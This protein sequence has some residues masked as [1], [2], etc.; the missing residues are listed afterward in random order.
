MSYAGHVMDMI[1]RIKYNESLKQ[2]RRDRY[3]M[4]K[5]A[6]LE[7]IHYHIKTKSDTI[8]KEKLEGIKQKIR[9]DLKREYKIFLIKTTL[10]T[11]FITV[12][13]ALLIYYRFFRG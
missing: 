3:K 2:A 5:E 12:A 1:N 10:T 8:P 4:L 9:A 7:G 13:I 11:T 6:Y